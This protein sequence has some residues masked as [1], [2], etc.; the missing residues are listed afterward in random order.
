MSDIDGRMTPSA[1]PRDG[2]LPRG[3]G[4]FFVRSPLPL[5]RFRI[6]GWAL[7]ELLLWALYWRQHIRIAHVG[8]R[9]GKLRQTVLEVIR[10]DPDAG[11][12]IVAAMFGPRSD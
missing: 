9:S 12:W 11:E 7:G 6:R 4:R 1:G 3:I 8:R 2:W 10:H 5:Y